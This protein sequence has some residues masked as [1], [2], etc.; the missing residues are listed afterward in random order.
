[1]ATDEE[2]YIRRMFLSY[3]DNNNGVLD[4]EEFYK[5]LK[6]MIQQLAEDQT[7]EEINKIAEEATQKFDL[8]KNGIIEFD[9]FN[10]LVRFLID[11]KGLS[12][13]N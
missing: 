4:R 9:E 8:N 5:V 6:S 3:D 13:N 11:E 12:I 10:H 1:M 7:E 2:T